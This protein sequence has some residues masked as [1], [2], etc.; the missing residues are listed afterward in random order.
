M[1]GKKY[2]MKYLTLIIT[3]FSLSFDLNAQVTE[4]RKS[5]IEGFISGCKKHN[6]TKIILEHFGRKNG[7]KLIDSYCTCRANFVVDNLTFKQLEQIYLGKEK[8]SETLF[9]R[10]EYECTRQFDSL[11][12]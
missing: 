1:I 11:I 7:E 2:N 8:M 12:K 3:L 5:M 4:H 6:D 10:M 9:K